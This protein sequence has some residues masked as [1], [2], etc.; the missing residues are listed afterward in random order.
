MD[1]LHRTRNPV[2]EKQLA[3]FGEYLLQKSIV[4]PGKERFLVHWARRF[5]QFSEKYPGHSWTEQLQMFLDSLAGDSRV[6]DWQLQQAEEAVRLLFT[7]FLTPSEKEQQ[8]LVLINQGQDTHFSINEALSKFKEVL[9]LKHYAYRTEQTYLDW[10]QRF[11]AY[12]AKQPDKSTS[13]GLTITEKSVQD[14]LAYLAV[15]RK[16]SA[17]TQNQAFCAI[18]AFCRSVLRLD[19]GGIQENVRAPKKRKLPVVLSPTETAALFN[20]VSGPMNLMLRLIYGGGLRLNECLR[21]RVKD[22]DLSQ[23]LIFVRDGKGGKD[24]STLL[25]ERLK[26]L[27]Q[28][29]LERIQLLHQQDLAKGFGEVWMPE[30]LARKYPTACREFGWQFVFPS[31]NLSIDPRS[32]VTRRHHL[33]DSAIQKAMKKAVRAAGINKLASVHTLRHSFAT[34]L[35]L[36]GVDLRQIQDYLGHANVETTMIYTHVIKDMRNPGVSPL[37]FLDELCENSR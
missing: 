10:L 17:S 7:N 11:F 28:E 32:K 37:D 5:Y 14:Y 24:R 12:C 22:L 9:R 8:G 2:L 36:K 26:P 34:H 29:Q 4:A 25:P 6:E 27:L 18:L 33:S 15:K 13:E 21:L 3:K 16:V 23:N 30:A 35:L 31:K 19:L 1:S 20:H